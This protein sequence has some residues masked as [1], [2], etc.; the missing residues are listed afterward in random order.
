MHHRKKPGLLRPTFSPARKKDGFQGFGMPMPPHIPMSPPMPPPHAP[1]PPAPPAPPP[2]SYGYPYEYALPM[3]YPP[4]IGPE[5][6]T[7]APSMDDAVLL[8]KIKRLKKQADKEASTQKE[9]LIS[10]LARW[11]NQ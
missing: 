1:P 6:T 10:M 8:E 7:P 9:S 2:T 3:M 4:V 11:W 5:F